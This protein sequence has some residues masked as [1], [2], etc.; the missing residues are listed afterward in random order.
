MYG[1][2]GNTHFQ[3]IVKS[4]S[5]YAIAFQK[6]DLSWD[7]ID[8]SW[9]VQAG[10]YCSV[11]EA[12][13]TLEYDA[14]AFKLIANDVTGEVVVLS[15]MLEQGANPSTPIAHEEDLRGMDGDNHEFIFTRNTT[16]IAPDTPLSTQEDDLEPTGWTDN[17]QGVTKSFLSS[18][19]CER[20]RSVWLD[21]SP[22]SLWAKW[23]EDGL[24]VYLRKQ[25]HYETRWVGTEKVTDIVG[26]E[27]FGETEL[28]KVT[29]VFHKG[30]EDVAPT[31]S[32]SRGFSMVREWGSFT[33]I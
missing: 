12:G 4:D 19:S 25:G 8:L 33:C 3:A 7:V 20:K 17:P 9:Q 6:P 1:K 10:Q 5:G 16:G 18:L 30:E 23:S 32:L 26:G 13:F 28:I 15:P 22:P 2:R 31:E 27:M 11:L 14:V 21:F 29:A 24:S